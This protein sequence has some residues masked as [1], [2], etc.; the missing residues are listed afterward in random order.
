ME[1]QD[2]IPKIFISYS[3]DSKEHKKWV[4]NLSNK[5]RN[6]AIGTIIDQ[7][8]LKVG[9]NL[10]SFMN[11]I[12]EVDRVLVICTKKYYEKSQSKKGG[13]AYENYLITS[14]IIQNLGSEK[15]IPIIRQDET[16][17]DGSLFIPTALKG[18]RHLDFSNDFEF[19]NEYKDLIKTL[20]NIP[21]VHKQAIGTSPFDLSDENIEKK[22]IEKL[23]PIVYNYLMEEEKV[24]YQV[25]PNCYLRSE[26]DFDTQLKCE[27]EYSMF[28]FAL[29]KLIE[30][31]SV[32]EESLQFSNQYTKTAYGHCFVIY[33]QKNNSDLR[34]YNTV[35]TLEENCEVKYITSTY[36]ETNFKFPEIDYI[37]IGRIYGDNLELKVLRF[38]DNIKFEASNDVVSRTYKTNDIKKIVKL[39]EEAVRGEVI[40]QIIN[41]DLSL[42]TRIE[43]PTD[44]FLI[45]QFYNAKSNYPDRASVW[46][47]KKDFENFIDILKSTNEN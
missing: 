10:G 34:A 1:I 39:F 6:D 5:L 38:Q 43:S 20:H 23:T 37:E 32:I 8:D 45:F 16:R 22:G 12:E 13:V 18:L 29:K 14:E 4:L 21:L 40:N 42:E 24:E 7:A 44:W 36:N 30:K 2:N 19:E 15:F 26:L 31:N 28:I 47:N 25:L 35:I 17:E 9:G 46:I 33:Y 3:H 41:K 27:N 11:L